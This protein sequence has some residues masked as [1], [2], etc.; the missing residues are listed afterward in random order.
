MNRY[1]SCGLGLFMAASAF[2]AM[3]APSFGQ[4][5]SSIAVKASMTQAPAATSDVNNTPFKALKHVKPC[6]YRRS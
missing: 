2:S 1:V 6:P 4:A 3:A 5:P